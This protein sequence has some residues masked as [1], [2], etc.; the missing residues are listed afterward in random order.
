MQDK[1]T[2][3]RKALAAL[4]DALPGPDDVGPYGPGGPVMGVH[5][6]WVNLNPQP[7]PPREALVSG[8]GHPIPWRQVSAPGWP[9]PWR[10]IASAR[11]VI[12]SMLT[13]HQIAAAAPKSELA[14]EMTANTRAALSAYVEDFCGTRWP[15]WRIPIPLPGPDPDPPEPRPIDLIFAGLQF[16]QAAQ[17][18]GGELG[19]EFDNA[20]D[21]LLET[22][23][24]KAN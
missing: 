21:R 10:A 4:L 14:H 3:S 18:I 15:R 11:S 9:V 23:F 8:P 1:L 12:R 19:N 6:D 22:G 16:Q 24:A 7:L 20:A 5:L 13:V 2:V 17:R